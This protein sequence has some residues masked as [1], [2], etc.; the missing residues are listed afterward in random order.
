MSFFCRFLPVHW[1]QATVAALVAA[2]A[3]LPAA[4]AA[5]SSP[6]DPPTAEVKYDNTLAKDFI[7]DAPW[8]VIDDQTVIPLTIILKDCDVDDIRD[9]HWIRCWDVTGG[10]S[11]VLWDHD[12]GDETIGNDASEDNYWTYITT[13]TEGHPGL[14]NGT[15]LTPANLGYGAGDAIQ[16]KVSIYYR[17]DW[18]NYTETRYL[19]VHVGS[20]PFPWPDDW[21]GGDTHYHSMYTNN[22]AEF[23]AP[24]PAVKLTAV[25]LGLHWVTVTDHSCDLDE[26]GDGTYSYA[27]HQWEYTLQTPVG[28]QTFYRDVF[29]HGS[30][31]GG[32]G[33]D[34]SELDGP[35]CR[36][37]RGVEINL[38][39]I[40][41]DHY[42][43]TLHCL[44]YNPDYIP[45]PLCGAIGER[46]VSPLL[47]DGLDQMAA[48]GLAYAAHPLNDLG[49]E[50]GGIDWTVNGTT[51]GDQDLTTALARETF[52][53]L[54]SF[55]TR[56]TRYSSDQNNPWSDFDAG[57]PP[58][59]PYPAELLAG[60]AAWDE[61]L[62]SHLAL[63]VR[64][65]FLAGGSDA[66]G[67]FNFASYVSLDNYATDNAIG[68]V[69]TVVHV[70][71]GYAPGNLP[72]MSEILAA[73]RAGRSVVTD[74]PFLEI[75]I[76]N[77]GDGDWYDA[78]DLEIGS[79]GVLNPEICPPLQLRWASLPEFGPAT[80]VR[81]LIGQA[82]GTTTLLDFDPTTAGEGYEG[83][84][85][86][87]LSGLGLGGSYY[88]RAELLTADSDAGHRAYTNPVWVFFDPLADVASDENAVGAEAP[89][90]MRLLA[91]TPNPFNPRTEIRFQLREPGAVFLAIHDLR[92]RA[93]RELL[94]DRPL[95]AGI[96]TVP[97]DGRDERG[98]AMPSG[99]YL[100]RLKAAGDQSWR[101]ILL[102][103]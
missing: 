30:S 63:P 48:E 28:S 13:V 55:N 51:W 78:G 75:G 91:N 65:I 24:V 77:D 20:G 79:D 18:F 103:R 15:L 47:P 95:G 83:E 1:Q 29:A 93:V 16:L 5:T 43:Q 62:R 2:L 68:K 100:V 81:L 86:F 9:L 33:A 42:E 67:D 92:G 17:D 60:I 49:G 97:W 37:F 11:T 89:H 84:T 3:V 31:W 88:L 102:V 12:F 26:T 41:S 87:D 69:Q 57:V 14:I 45:S 98:E 46:P 40:D 99:T 73:Y 19:R 32:L 52:R 61:L 39:S 74:G 70:P 7:M 54:E 36:L 90:R 82:G 34:V 72:P 53:G 50:W 96:H 71:G 44:F 23:G 85:G 101:K 59:H 56:E 27:T 35:D 10:G 22:I 38:A 25:A 58:D 64:K 66:H 4:P 6:T 94:R 80:S 21:Y 8:R 76:D